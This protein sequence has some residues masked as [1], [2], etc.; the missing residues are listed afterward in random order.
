MG[1]LGSR[2]DLS[3]VGGS[4]GYLDFDKDK[5]NL[6][7]IEDSDGNQRVHAEGMVVRKRE[8]V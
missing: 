5:I 4:V 2:L 6:H 1:E 7:R 8:C 3:I